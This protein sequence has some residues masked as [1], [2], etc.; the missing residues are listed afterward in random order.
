MRYTGQ[1]DILPQN[2]LV[3]WPT[4]RGGEGCGRPDEVHGAGRHLAP[5]H[6]RALA[7][8]MGRGGVREAG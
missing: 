5:E 6:T 1:P 8:C 4:A 7:N 2:T 3:R